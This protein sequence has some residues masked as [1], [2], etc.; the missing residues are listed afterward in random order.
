MPPST[1]DYPEISIASMTPK[2]F[3]YYIIP[4]NK[5]PIMKSQE[6]VRI[7]KT[8]FMEF[9]TH[10]YPWQVAVLWGALE[11]FLFYSA[12]TAAGTA[13]I[14]VLYI[15][16]AFLLG[17]FSWTFAEYTLHRWLFHFKPKTPIQERISFLFHGVHHE[18]PMVKTRLVMPFPVSIPLASLF[19]GLFYLICSF[20]F[21][22]PEWMAPAFAGFIAGYMFY[23]LGHYAFHHSKTKNPYIVYV[24]KHHMRHHGSE[25][26]LRFGVSNP[27]WDYVFG[28]MP[29][30]DENGKLTN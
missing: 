14:K 6:P 15:P 25:S 11:I 27:L 23:D 9:F 5:E 13:G 7:F 18:Q 26:H 24:R 2:P 22:R 21:R 12:I 28:T 1:V 17:L 8:D 10:I 30:Y 4:I 3:I 20:V 29:R 16:V 19:L